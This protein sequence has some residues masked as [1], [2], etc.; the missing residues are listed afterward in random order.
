MIVQGKFAG[1]AFAAAL[2]TT[3]A[4]LAATGA[5]VHAA[6]PGAA[7]AKVRSVAVHHG[8]LDLST[9]AG[10]RQLENRV[11]KA[12]ERLCVNGGT[13]PLQAA[14]IARQC[15]AEA[16]AGAA[17]QVRLATARQ[18]QAQFASRALANE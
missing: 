7:P 17:P 13:A 9:S 11:R 12:A 6:E 1:L 15:I 5:P 2:L 10:L 4:T 16:V 8:D 14:V 3:A 18:R